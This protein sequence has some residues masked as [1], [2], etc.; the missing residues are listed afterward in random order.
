LFGNNIYLV[1]AV[2]TLSG[3]LDILS[4]KV[5]ECAWPIDLMHIKLLGEAAEEAFSEA[6]KLTLCLLVAPL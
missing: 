1:T 3:P 5:I 4:S 6:S 2:P